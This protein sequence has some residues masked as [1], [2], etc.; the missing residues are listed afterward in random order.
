MNPEYI[1]IVAVIILHL[2]P[3]FL[4]RSPSFYYYTS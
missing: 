3:L 1:I 2:L 4:T